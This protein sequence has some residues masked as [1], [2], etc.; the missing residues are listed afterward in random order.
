[1]ILCDKEDG[2]TKLMKASS[3]TEIEQFRK[4]FSLGEL[5][6]QGAVGAVP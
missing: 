4:H 2:F 6:S 5:W 3:V 1:M